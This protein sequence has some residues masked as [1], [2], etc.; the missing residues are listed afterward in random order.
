MSVPATPLSPGACGSSLADERGRGRRVVIAE[1]ERGNNYRILS[2]YVQGLAAEFR[3]RGWQVDIP[4]A[5]DPGFVSRLFRHGEDPEAIALLG[6]F[7]YDLRLT[8]QNLWSNARFGDLFRGRACA[9][10]ADHPFTGFMWPR[11]TEA[12]PRILYC[13]ADPGFVEA[14]RWINPR[15]QRFHPTH[16]PSLYPDE[17]PSPHERRGVDVLIPL[18]YRD[19]GSRDALIAELAAQPDE[20]A[21]AD[22]L[23]ERLSGD[24]QTYPLALLAQA[25]TRRTGLEAR[26]WRADRERLKAWLSLLGRVDLIVRN[27]RRRRL[28][29]D[30]LRDTGGLKVHLVGRLPPDLPVPDHVVQEGPLSA[31]ELGARMRDARWVVHCHPT[32]P[33]AM[34][35]RVLGAMTLGCAVASDDAPVLRE[36]FREGETWACLPAGMSI[37]GLVDRVPGP[38]AQAMA[39]QARALARTHDMAS[40]VDH[41]L[42]GLDTLS[43]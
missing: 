10:W 25:V 43:V 28:T 31:D 11:I 26:V 33:G 20:R 12:D 14:A 21:V 35:E 27:E 39:D 17:T 36:H 13:P 29:L 18:T 9:L 2:T 24:R 8:A 19:V 37:A 6:H 22:E 38:A 42:R 1:A 3:R 40:H 15:L 7:F 5:G 34:H 4:R 30:L 41:L 32:Y 23:F 16:L